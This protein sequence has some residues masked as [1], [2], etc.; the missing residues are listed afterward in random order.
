MHP[1]VTPEFQLRMALTRQEALAEWLLEELASE[2]RWTKSFGRSEEAL[3]G[4]ADEALTEYREDRTRQLD[5]D[6]L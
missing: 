3:G 4:L 2:R 5:P 1:G 6:K